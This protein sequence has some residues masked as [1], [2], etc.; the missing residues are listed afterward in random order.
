VVRGLEDAELEELARVVPLVERVAHLEPF[1]ALEPDQIGVEDTG[2]GGCE[3]G[4]AHAGFAFEEQR[5]PQADRKEER[6]G[7]ASIRDVGVIEQ[8]RLEVV[9]RDGRRR[10]TER[11]YSR[12][13]REIC[14]PQLS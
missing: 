6:D 2:D 12:K 9:D 4:L 3:G 11:Y 13:P 14:V 1:V 8:P 7:K 10:H 5:T